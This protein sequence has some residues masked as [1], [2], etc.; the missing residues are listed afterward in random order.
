MNIR[1]ISN[2]QNFT[3]RYRV[4]LTQDE[5]EDFKENI[6]PQLDEMHNGRVDYLYGRSPSEFLFAEALEE[7]ANANNASIDWAAQNLANHGTPVSG[8][9]SAILWLTT[10]DEDTTRYEKFDEKC[11]K[12]FR[13]RAEIAG[14]KLIGENYSDELFTLKTVEKA[15]NKEGKDF[16]RF[17][18]KFPFEK[19]RN[20]KEILQ[21]EQNKLDIVL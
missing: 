3:S 4:L 16:Y 7:Y 9:D 20:V 13:L 15:L 14:F 5:F 1:P 18:K 8:S 10:G 17:I 21:K 19:I 6:L 12:K 2:P 11:A